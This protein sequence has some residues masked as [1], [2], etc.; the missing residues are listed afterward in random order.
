MFLSFEGLDGCGKTTQVEL[1]A[2]RL[3]NIGHKVLVLREPG[4][5]TI[6]ED[7]REILLNKKNSSMFSA[8]E[9]LLFSAAR[10]QLVHEVILP[11]L[12][13]NCVVIC[14]RYVDSTTAYQGFGRGISQDTIRAINNIAT[15]RLFPMKTFFIDIPVEEA[16]RRRNNSRIT[17][18]R[19]EEAETIFFQ[20][21][22]DGFHFIAQ[23]EPQRLVTI[24]GMNSIDIVHQQIWNLVTQQF[25]Q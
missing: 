3:T 16:L 11:S 23:Q 18:D 5:T 21:I 6:S 22:F 17:T 19:M 25:A 7:I 12:K 1:L 14:D 10:A 15:Q 20:H 2:R 4:G 13:R 24:D 9:M 8:T